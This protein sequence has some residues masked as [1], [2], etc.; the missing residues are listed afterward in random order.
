MALLINFAYNRIYNS[1]LCCTFGKS[2]QKTGFMILWYAAVLE[3]LPVT[4]FII[5]W[6]AAP[7]EKI[8]KNRIH[9]SMVCVPAG[10][11]C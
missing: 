2:C 4:G 3:T 6:F 5:L 1:V 8:A 10:N 9:D 7:L 11:L